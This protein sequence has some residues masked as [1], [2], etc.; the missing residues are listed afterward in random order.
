MASSYVSVDKQGPVAVVRFDRR[1]NLNAINQQLVRELTEVGRELHDDLETHCVVLAGAAEAFSAGA[2]LRDAASWQPAQ[3]TDVQRRHRF[4]AGVRLCRVWEEM[5]QITIAA[6]ERMA[7]GAGVAIALACDWRVLG[8]GGFL[9]V[10]E[11]KIGL[12]LQ[13][14]ALPRLVTLVGPARAKRITLMCEKT[15]AATALAWGL[16]DEL[17]ED[18]QTVE[19]A[20]AMARKTS[21]MPPA[22]VRL[23]KEAINATAGALQRVSSFADGDQSQLTGSF[24]AA[25]AAR[26]QFTKR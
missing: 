18:G 23:M 5:P 17:A 22:T 7:V 14:G 10:P 2:D 13:W 6:I 11:V 15:D 26:E 25:R 12:N 16:V 20:L 4:Y 21:A 9:Y 3:K 24:E 19:T 1:E 8:R